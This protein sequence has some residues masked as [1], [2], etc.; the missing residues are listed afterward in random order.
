MSGPNGEFPDFDWRALV[1]DVRAG[2]QSIDA[3]ARRGLDSASNEVRQAALQDVAGAAA[4]L[5]WQLSDLLGGI[6]TRSSL[7][8]FELD[9]WAA[10]ALRGLAALAEQQRKRLLLDVLPGASALLTTDQ[11]VLSRVLQNLVVNAIRYSDS[12]SIL[13]EL[14]ADR[15]QIQLTVRNAA[16]RLSREDWSSLMAPGERAANAETAG[17]QRARGSGLGITIANALA[18]RLGGACMVEA[19][20]GPDGRVEFQSWAKLPLPTHPLP[21]AALPADHVAIIVDSRPVERA[22]LARQLRRLG[23]PVGTRQGENARLEIRDLNGTCTAAVS[24]HDPRLGDPPTL[25]AV[26]E[27]LLGSGYT[28]KHLLLVDD[29]PVTLAGLAALA[30]PLG[31]ASVRCARDRTT[32]LRLAEETPFDHAVID[33]RL[34]SGSGKALAEELRPH[35]AHT[36]LVSADAGAEVQPRPRSSAELSAL[37]G[38]AATSAA[39]GADRPATPWEALDD[40]LGAIITHLGNGAGADLDLELHGLLGACEVWGLEPL[41]EQLKAAREAL[42]QHPG[43][44]VNALMVARS[45]LSVLSR[46]STA[47]G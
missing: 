31:F 44:A 23:W 25:R 35:L 5:E 12:D 24:L 2:L 29:N 39:D 17:E 14:R 7:E 8:A 32:A 6:D 33:L 22:L 30:A 37:L 45:R 18:E 41:V 16:E 15:G 11:T 21:L 47:G 26:I 38:G 40:A 4:A 46:D 20:A 9:L 42:A 27:A 10:A 1:H 36:V 28:G 19:F 13:V 34:G 43:E 3:A